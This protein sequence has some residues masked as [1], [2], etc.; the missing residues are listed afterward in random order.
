MRLPSPCHGPC[1]SRGPSRGLCPPSCPAQAPPLTCTSESPILPASRRRSAAP[2]YCCRWKELSRVLSCS[3]LKAVRSRRP[4]PRPP[5]SSG[6]EHSGP[7]SGGGCSA[8]HGRSPAPGKK[9]ERG[10]RG[11]GTAWVPARLLRFRANTTQ[12]V[13]SRNPGVA[14]GPSVLP[15]PAPEHRYAPTAAGNPR[16]PAAGGVAKRS[17]LLPPVPSRGPADRSSLR[18]LKPGLE[19]GR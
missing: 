11:L 4:P 3:A 17:L 8:P 1:P 9:E 18:S 6:P 16:L 10:Q 2:R 13:L 14:Q 5:G 19:P 7:P 12:L 15:V